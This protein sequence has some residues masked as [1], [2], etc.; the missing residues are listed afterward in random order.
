MKIKALTNFAG[1]NFSFVKGQIA[2]IDDK[3]GKSLI[4]A[5]LAEEVREKKI[6]TATL[7]SADKATTRSKKKKG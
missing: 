4:K 5:G 3:T 2:D 1:I 6:E 7:G